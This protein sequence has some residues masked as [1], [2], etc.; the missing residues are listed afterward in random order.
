MMNCDSCGTQIKDGYVFCPNCGKEI[1]ISSYKSAVI[2]AL[3]GDNRGFEYLYNNTANDKYYIALKY[4]KNQEDA[5]DVLQ[6]AYLR[7]W[8]KLDTLDDPD[9]FPSWVGMIVA[10]TA[11]NALQK[12][13]P[14]LFTELENDEGEIL[15]FQIE[16][17]SIEANPEISVTNQERTEIIKEMLDA[18]SE[19]QRLCITMFYLEDRSIKEIAEI[20][21]CS[22]NTVKSRL[23]YGRKNLAT[24]GEEMKKKGY[25]F[26]GIAPLPLLIYLIRSEAKA[27][28]INLGLGGAS[29]ATGAIMTATSATVGELTQG[30]N[31]TGTTQL[32]TSATVKTAGTKVA[33]GIF[34]TMAGKIAVGAGVAVLTLGGLV[35]IEKIT[36]NKDNSVTTEIT[37]TE[38]VSYT[39]ASSEVTSLDASIDDTT[40]EVVEITTEEVVDVDYSQILVDLKDK[41]QLPTNSGVKN[42]YMINGDVYEL[43]QYAIFDINN[44]GY[45]ELIIRNIQMED[46]RDGGDTF[47]YGYNPEL[48]QI[49]YKFSASSYKPNIYENGIIVC[50][51]AEG[52]GIEFSCFKYNQ[53]TSGYEK[54]YF[55]NFIICSTAGDDVKAFDLNGNSYIKYVTNPDGTKSIIDDDYESWISENVGDSLSIELE[56]FDVETYQP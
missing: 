25:Q 52:Q 49:E 21:E 51:F 42:I 4:M 43:G 30:V 7:A 27:C 41:G 50:R 11:K 16:D 56:Y 47:V 19:D 40:E 6:D 44:D 32:A 26:F 39:T 28:G 1:K 48:K 34:K 15:E 46:S 20:L 55:N 31:L 36:N 22:E 35:A 14:V 33:G 53:E 37:T 18:L 38:N 2:A 9:K 24:K 29:T 3:S 23:N 45:D 13:N 8:N 17:E 12:K 54:V 10:N 5:D